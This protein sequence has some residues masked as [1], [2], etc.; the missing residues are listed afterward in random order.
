MFQL[1]YIVIQIAQDWKYLMNNNQQKN[2][3]YY[4]RIDK[5]VATYVES[6]LVQNKTPGH[7]SLNWTARPKFPLILLKMSLDS[8]SSLSA[9]GKSLL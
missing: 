2:Y 3:K 9:Y 8:S 6:F 4:V 5:I 7:I 1:H